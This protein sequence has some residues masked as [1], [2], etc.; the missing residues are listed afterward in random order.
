M[1]IILKAARPLA[2]DTWSSRPAPW[3]TNFTPSKVRIT[4]VAPGGEPPACEV[5]SWHISGVGNVIGN[6]TGATGEVVVDL[7]YGVGEY[8]GRIVANGYTSISKIEF[9]EDPGPEPWY[10][11]TY[12][13][14]D[15]GSAIYWDSA[16]TGWSWDSGENEWVKSEGSGLL[17]ADTFK[18]W[19]LPYVTTGTYHFWPTKMRITGT[20]VG[21]ETVTLKN[22]TG[23][24]TIGSASPSSVTTLNLNNYPVEGSGND[25]IIGALDLTAFSFITK[26][27]MNFPISKIEVA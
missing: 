7:T 18:G 22:K 3:M 1:S 2:G 25:L 20:V 15:S 12:L 16:G 4:G 17:T 19:P 9:N 10:D 26:I 24:I 21:S 13:G 14:G 6:F 27:E 5:R 8:F 11:V 23:D